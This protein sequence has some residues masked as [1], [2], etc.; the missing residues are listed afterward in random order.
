MGIRLFENILWVCLQK[1]FSYIIMNQE[2]YFLQC[3]YAGRKCWWQSKS[4]YDFF[5]LLKHFGESFAVLNLWKHSNSLF[6]PNKKINSN[7]APIC[8]ISG[9]SGVNW[10]SFWYSNVLIFMLNEHSDHSEHRHRL[11]GNVCEYMRING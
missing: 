10:G 7:K 2:K 11:C 4:D 5:F 9:K 1:L 3:K 6:F 8:A